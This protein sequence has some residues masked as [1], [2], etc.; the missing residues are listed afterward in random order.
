MSEK[1]YLMDRS[2]ESESN[3]WFALTA[4][5]TD[6]QELIIQYICTKVA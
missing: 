1:I 2:A 6:N 3:Y 4:E 5:L